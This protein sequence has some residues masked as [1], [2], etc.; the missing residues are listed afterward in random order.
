MGGSLGNRRRTGATRQPNRI[1]RERL[2]CR[3][4]DGFCARQKS[5]ESDGE[6]KRGLGENGVLRK[7]LRSIEGVSTQTESIDL[8]RAVATFLKLLGFGWAGRLLGRT[9]GFFLNQSL[10]R[11]KRGFATCRIAIFWS[12]LYG[13][14]HPVF[15]GSHADHSPRSFR[16]DRGDQE[17]EGEDQGLPGASHGCGRS[18]LNAFKIMLGQNAPFRDEVPVVK[19]QG[20]AGAGFGADRG[21]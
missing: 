1:V 14:C 12:G 8:Y 16:P 15:A 21:V 6:P 18:T 4:I 7:P 3:R 19:I 2:V 17:R 20:R 9:A 5:L 13:F 10:L 11:Q